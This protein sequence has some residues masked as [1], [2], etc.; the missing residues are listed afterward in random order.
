MNI[1]EKEIT[2]C[3]V[4]VHQVKSIENCLKQSRRVSFDISKKRAG[5]FCV[6]L[7]QDGSLGY[8]ILLR[9]DLSIST[10]VFILFHEMD[11]FFRRDQKQSPVQKEYTAN[12]YA[13]KI[14]K[15]RG[16]NESMEDGA[17]LIRF[18]ATAKRIGEVDR[19][20]AKKIV[21]TALFKKVI[22]V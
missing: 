16:Y 22:N 12:M 13:L 6:Y 17:S 9:R 4:P 7:K 8:F 1:L 2:Q 11:H 14:C 21:G 18:M 3:P 19:A 5:S 15:Q 10:K 20:A